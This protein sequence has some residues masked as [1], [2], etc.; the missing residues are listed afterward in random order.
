MLKGWLFGMASML[1]GAMAAVGQAIG[2][3]RFHVG[4]FIYNTEKVPILVGHV[5]FQH[6][7]ERL[8]THYCDDSSFPTWYSHHFWEVKT[9]PV[10][11]MCQDVAHGSPWQGNQDL[12]L[13]RFPTNQGN[14]FSQTLQ[15]SAVTRSMFRRNKLHDSWLNSKSLIA[16]M[17]EKDRNFYRTPQ[18][19][20][21]KP[22][23]NRSNAARHVQMPRQHWNVA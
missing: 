13:S 1:S 3:S 17:K 18:L 9:C 12:G 19:E 10:R 15:Y 5:W 22:V 21:E 2:K 7:F 20:M 23:K 4:H 11:G 14:R 16:S 6:Q 8:G